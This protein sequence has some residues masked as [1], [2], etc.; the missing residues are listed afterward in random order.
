[1]SDPVLQLL[2]CHIAIFV[3]VNLAHYYTGEGRRWRE[4]E[5]G[6][7]EGGGGGRREGGGG[8]GRRRNEGGGRG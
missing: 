1:M 3:K 5:R 6:R 4:G 7:K 8:G 2:L